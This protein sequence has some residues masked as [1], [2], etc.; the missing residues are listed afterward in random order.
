MKTI[1]VV[2]ALIC[3]GEKF[4]ICRRPANKAR[5]GLYEFPG[6]KVESGE[7]PAEALCREC[8]EELAIDVDV[9]MPVADV[10][11]SYPDLTIHLTL[12]KALLPQG[13]PTPL[14]HDELRWI[15]AEQLNDYPFCPADVAFHEPIRLL[16]QTGHNND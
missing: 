1:E 3:R 10:T 8:R 2:A 13:E 6:G 7:T 4:L 16:M 14:E 9:H 11:H 5:G 12:L 15:T